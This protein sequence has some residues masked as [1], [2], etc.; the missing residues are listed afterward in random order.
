MEL[1]ESVPRRGYIQQPR[2]SVAQP[3]VTGTPSKTLK[4]FHKAGAVDNGRIV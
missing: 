2:V 4:G 3:W 1:L